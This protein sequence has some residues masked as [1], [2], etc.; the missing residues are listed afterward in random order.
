[1][2]KTTTT[3]KAKSVNSAELLKIKIE[4][5]LSKMV[6]ALE[7]PQQCVTIAYIYA[8]R[9]VKRMMIEKFFLSPAIAEK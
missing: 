2:N 8:E 9:A 5:T 1:M 3:P 7:L 4:G 6:N